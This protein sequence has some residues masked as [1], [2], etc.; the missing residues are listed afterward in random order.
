VLEGLES[1]TCLWSALD[2]T[3]PLL[4]VMDM[5]GAIFDNSGM[6]VAGLMADNTVRTYDAEM[7]GWV[8]GTAS[9]LGF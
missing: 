8:G 9:W 3:T 6:R 2:P 1:E 5:R 7:G 4:R